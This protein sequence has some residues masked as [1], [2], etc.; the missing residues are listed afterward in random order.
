MRSSSCLNKSPLLSGRPCDAYGNYLPPDSPPSPH[1]P[2]DDPCDWSPYENR[3]EFETAEFL[4]ARNQMSG[5]DIDILLNLWAASLAR[6]DDDPPFRSHEDIYNTID[7]TPL[8]DV[9]WESFSLQYNSNLPAGEVPPWMTSKFDVWFRDP[10]TIVKNLLANP[11]FDNEF[12]YS[13]VQEYDME[14]NHRFQN[15]MS[16]NW[17]WKQAASHHLLPYRISTVHFMFSSSRIS[18]QKILGL[19]DQCSSQSF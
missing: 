18:L 10:H 16:G 13:P 8:G 6:H 2:T 19:T 14:G 9:P 4:F 5:G 11:D 1:R 7:S 17:G 12:D 15:F 3:L